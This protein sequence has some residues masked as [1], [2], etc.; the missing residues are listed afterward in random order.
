LTTIFLNDFFK[1]SDFFGEYKVKKALP[2][3]SSAIYKTNGIFF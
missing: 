2:I 1:K 3:A